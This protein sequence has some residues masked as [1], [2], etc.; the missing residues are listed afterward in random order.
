[1]KTIILILLLFFLLLLFIM[2]RDN[3]VNNNVNSTSVSC[4]FRWNYKRKTGQIKSKKM[5]EV[6]RKIKLMVLK[7]K[8]ELRQIKLSD[9]KNLVQNDQ[10]LFDF[11]ILKT[12]DLKQSNVK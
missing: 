6:N 10:S 1:M 5:E 7:S 8:E 4:I 9:A 2:T 12:K 3:Y 11:S